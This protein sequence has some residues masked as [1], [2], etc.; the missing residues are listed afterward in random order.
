[1]RRRRPDIAVAANG[2]ILA[3]GLILAFLFPGTITSLRFGDL[4]LKLREVHDTV[5]EARDLAKLLEE[6]AELQQSIDSSPAETLQD[7]A[8]K[9]R[10]LSAYLDQGHL[11]L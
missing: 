3:A 4:E 10:R 8:V 2:Y 9:L 1:M 7:A 6:I 11:M 5:A